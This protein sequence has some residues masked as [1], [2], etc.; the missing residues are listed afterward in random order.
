MT[1]PGGRRARG[2]GLLALFLLAGWAGLVGMAIAAERARSWTSAFAEAAGAALCLFLA[3]L[4]WARARA[5]RR[6][7]VRPPHVPTHRR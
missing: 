7:E 3:L 6:G 2:L 4:L 5:V 1:A